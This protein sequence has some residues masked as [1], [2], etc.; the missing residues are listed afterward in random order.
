MTAFRRACAVVLLILAITS[1]APP[2][3]EP[4]A[5]AEKPLIQVALLLDTSN[6]MD[7]LINQA[8]TQLWTI[9]N[10]FA[11]TKQDG[12]TPV[13]QVAL[14]EYGN[15][16]LPASGG[17]IRQV[18]ALSDDLDKVSEKL[19]ALTT[20][21]GDEYCGQVIQVA[22]KDLAWST[23]PKVYRAIFIAGNEPF[24]QGTV[25]Y[26]QSCAEA[27]KRGIIVNTIHCGSSS[28]GLTTGWA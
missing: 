27:I 16:G 4:P 6:S 20:N 24:T 3:T 5:A 7:G 10:E 23:S 21:G 25:D 12:Q 1:L 15:S 14:Y 9:V 18:L 26:H 8:R 22:T 11:R 13:L 28:E 2:K 19:F 17:Y